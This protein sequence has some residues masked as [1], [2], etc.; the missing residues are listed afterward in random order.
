MLVL[1]MI[2]SLP[3]F[4]NDGLLEKDPNEMYRRAKKADL[5]FHQF[6]EWIQNDISRSIYCMDQNI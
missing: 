6:Y 5:D 3:K 2:L 1:S 4:V